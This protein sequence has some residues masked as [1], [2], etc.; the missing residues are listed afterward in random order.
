MNI[1]VLAGGYSAER[2]VSLVSGSNIVEAL[3]RRG[4]RALL[5]DPYKS[6]DAQPTFQAL[7]DAYAL[8]SY[9]HTIATT[10]PDLA[11]LRAQ[12]GDGEALLGRHVLE[13]CRLA[14]V[15]FLGLHGSYGENG[16]LQAAL[17]L[18]G[19][20]YT[21]SGHVGC[22][23]SMDKKISKTLMR[24]HGIQ[25][26]RDAVLEEK[27]FPL[28]VKPACGGSSIG[29]TIVQ[30]QAEL[31]Q[32]IGLAKSYE[33]EILVEEYIAGRLFSVGI[34]DGAALPV[35]EICPKSGW[36][37][38]AN[39]YQ[40]GATD[41]ICPAHIPGEMAQRMQEMALKVHAALRLGDY[42]RADFIVGNQ[43]EIYCLEAN[44]LPGMTPASLLPKEV[45]AAGIS[46]EE[47]CEK[48]VQL[49]LRRT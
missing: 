18:Y 17:D 26:P 11:H 19:I 12:F 23:L 24:L 25:T 47:L 9:S 28:I 46:Y 36:F 49:A 14:D 30:S 22:M 45:L 43:G 37:D 29:V 32:A 42:S 15:V 38:Y 21:G 41:E 13:A 6:I 48:L 16:Q 31:G 20:R 40:D 44:S 7:Y 8:E 5:L 39:K 27:R 2:D 1:L 33:N 34:L 4:H 10:E 35:I 3:R